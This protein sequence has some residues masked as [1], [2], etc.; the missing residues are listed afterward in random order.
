MPDPHATTRPPVA[1]LALLDCERGAHA[2]ARHQEVPQRRRA[3]LV[4]DPPRPAQ[5]EPPT[6]ADAAAPAPLLLASRA[7]PRASLA[8]PRLLGWHARHDTHQV[9]PLPGRA[10]ATRPVPRTSHVHPPVRVDQLDGTRVAWWWDAV[11]GRYVAGMGRYSIRSLPRPG[12]ATRP[13]PSRVP[14]GDA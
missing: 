9:A 10:V 2:V 12:D 14:G 11:H 1:A 8:D 13:T 6:R 5:D 7:L 4:P 3:T